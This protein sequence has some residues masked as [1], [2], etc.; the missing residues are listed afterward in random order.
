MAADTSDP[1]G[2]LRRIARYDAAAKIDVGQSPGGLLAC[3]F[4]EE[5]SSHRLDIGVTGSRAFLRLEA[6][7]E[8]DAT[9]TPPLNVFAGKSG[10]ADD[11]VPIKAFDGAVSFAM[12]QPERSD[13]VLIAETDPRG[14]LQMVA[15][16]RGEFVVVQSRGRSESTKHRRDLSF[17]RQGDRAAVGLRRRAHRR[18]GR[19][20]RRV[21]RFRR[22]NRIGRAIPTPGLAH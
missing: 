17:Q 11:Y 9:P 8:R 22:R 14:F 12:P 20:G 4:R 5:G 7:D 10:P 6:P 16:A 21:R 18:L 19:A 3:Y 2:Q 1:I 15:A 13:F